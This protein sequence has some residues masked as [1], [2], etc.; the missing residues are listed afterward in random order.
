MKI[1]ACMKMKKQIYTYTQR[2]LNQKL[3][4]ASIKIS[5]RFLNGIWQVDCK[6]LY[7]TLKLHLIQ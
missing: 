7:E 2:I 3:N 5:T 4:I 6:S 1:H